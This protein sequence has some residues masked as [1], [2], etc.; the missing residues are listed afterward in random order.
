MPEFTLSVNGQFRAHHPL[1]DHSLLNE[2]RHHD[3]DSVC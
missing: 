2:L 1:F 3:R